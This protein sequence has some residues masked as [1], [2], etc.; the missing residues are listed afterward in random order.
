MKRRL[1]EGRVGEYRG[2]LFLNVIYTIITI[3]SIV[4][5]FI[6]PI[7]YNGQLT[8]TNLVK[9]SPVNHLIDYGTNDILGYF[10]LSLVILLG[11][12]FISSYLCFSIPKLGKSVYVKI[13]KIIEI[14]LSFVALFALALSLYNTDT[15]YFKEHL[16]IYYSWQ[17]IL[18]SI[19]VLAGLN[20]FK[21]KKISIYD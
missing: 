12:T 6:V 19:I 9:L 1:N 18:I 14:L 15:T 3:V 16:I 20:Y 17:F 13:A 21:M 4:A 11:F 8:F 2:N 5:L 10:S 7:S